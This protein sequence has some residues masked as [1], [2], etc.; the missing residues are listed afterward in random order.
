M[1]SCSM[2]APMSCP[3]ATGWQQHRYRVY[4]VEAMIRFAG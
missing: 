2:T 4:G 1:A 3:S